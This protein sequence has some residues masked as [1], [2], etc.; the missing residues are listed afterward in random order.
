MAGDVPSLSETVP[1]AKELAALARIGEEALKYLMS[2]ESLPGDWRAAKLAQIEEISK[3]KA[4]VEFSVIQSFKEL[5]TAAAE[6]E[7]R[8][9]MSTEE[10]K[11][12]VKAL[13]TPKKPSN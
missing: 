4:A 12:H 3:P 13:A 11:K 9:T 2:N 7:K 10:W 6:R 8:R 1:L 5:V